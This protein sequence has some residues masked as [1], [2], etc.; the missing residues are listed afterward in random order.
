MRTSPTLIN[1]VIR[2]RSSYLF[3]D[4]TRW[5]HECMKR[6]VKNVL[7]GAMDFDRIGCTILFLSCEFFDGGMCGI[8]LIRGS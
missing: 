4:A 7:E 1:E 5:T 3:F 6:S 8:Q 2:S